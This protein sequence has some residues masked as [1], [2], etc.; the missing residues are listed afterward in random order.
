MIKITD[1][2]IN[3]CNDLLD[4][5]VLDQPGNGGAHHHYAIECAT[6]PNVAVDIRF[7][8]GPI[9]EVGVN[10]LTHEAL[11][12]ILLH[13]LRCFQAGPYACQANELALTHLVDAQCAL[14]SRTKE[15]M[16]RG[17]EGTHEV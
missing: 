12:A 13:R 10:G 7:Q 1:H 8:D 14:L 5:T 11:I 9:G 4:I 6:N 2:Q 17:V 3:P 15:R 16:H